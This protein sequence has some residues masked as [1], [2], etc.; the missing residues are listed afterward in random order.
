[1]EL[2][3]NIKENAKQ[4]FF[5]QLLKEFDYIEI[6]DVKDDD[7]SLPEEHKLLLDERLTKIEKGETTFR[8]WDEI[9]KKYEHTK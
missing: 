9:K 1:M 6:L 5:L 7:A 8:S 3:I 4:A 2:R